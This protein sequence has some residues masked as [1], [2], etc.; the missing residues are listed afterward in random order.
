MSAHGK[1]RCLSL[2]LGLLA[3]VAQPA[4]A[5]FLDAEVGARGIAM[6]GAFVAVEGDP[7]SLFWNPAAIFSD[8]RIQVSGMRTRMY[9]GLEGLSEDFLGLTGQIADDFAVGVGWTRTG[10]D[11]IYHED[12]VTAG[13]AWRVPRTGLRI[14]AAALFYG[15][16]APGYAELNDPNYLGAQW[17]PS[18]SFGLLY[19]WNENLHLGASFENLLKPEIAMLATTTDVD[20]IGGRRRVGIAY[21][22][23]DIVRITAEV[24]HHDF[25]QY[26]DSSWTLHGGAESWFNEVLALR[27]GVDDGDLTAGA[28]LLVKKVRFDVGM[29]TNERLGNTFRAALTVGY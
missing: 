21:L 2:L 16:D 10:L 12:V 13:M 1:V 4:R 7:A 17:E 3:A 11:D 24:R 9:D 8:Q 20:E 23:Q 28:G 22:L 15:V 26:Y 27:V 19:E 5:D 14:G 25:P 18:V 29:L 6:G